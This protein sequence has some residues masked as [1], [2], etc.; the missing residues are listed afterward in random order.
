MPRAPYFL[1]KPPAASPLQWS[2]ADQQPGQPARRP[3]SVGSAPMVPTNRAAWLPRRQQR[4]PT[5]RRPSQTPLSPSHT[6]FSGRSERRAGPLR[7]SA[8]PPPGR[9]CHCPR[10]GRPA[11]RPA[12]GPPRASRAPSSHDSDTPYNAHRVRDA[13]E[14][15]A[16]LPAT[17]AVRHVP[18]LGSRRRHAGGERAPSTRLL[19]AAG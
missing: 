7:D 14:S 10:V 16:V 1:L 12:P 2:A 13:I 17:P 19:C 6:H 9:H 18:A 4:R 15:A 8:P 11:Q 5:A 3:P